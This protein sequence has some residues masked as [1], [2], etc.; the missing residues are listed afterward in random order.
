MP[1]AA[2]PLLSPKT[3]SGSRSSLRQERRTV[4]EARCRNLVLRCV[5]VALVFAAAGCAKEADTSPGGSGSKEQAGDEQSGTKQGSEKKASS[6]GDKGDE[7]KGGGGETEGEAPAATLLRVRV[8]GEQ[9]RAPAEPAVS[10]GEPVR[11]VVS[12]DTPDEV[13]VHGY[14]LIARV[15]PGKR[16]EMRFRADIPGVFEVELEGSGR[17]LFELKVQ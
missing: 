6:K 9:I 16:A 15:R 17:L 10:V 2:P 5:L 8:T 12:S 13:H 7:K 11:M 1:G 14:D 3:A 4:I